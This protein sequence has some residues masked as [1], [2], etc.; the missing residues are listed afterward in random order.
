MYGVYNVIQEIVLQTR[1]VSPLIMGMWRSA[2]EGGLGKRGNERTQQQSNSKFV[3]QYCMTYTR[4]T[5]ILQSFGNYLSLSVNLGW[6]A[7]TWHAQSEYL[8]R[9]VLENLAG[10]EQ[11][12]WLWPHQDWICC[13]YLAFYCLQ[14]WG[15]SSMI[16][17]AMKVLH[18]LTCKSC[19]SDSWSNCNYAG[20][21]H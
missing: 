19:Q 17:Q 3:L 11:L 12:H 14:S 5:R 7:L 13:L 9:H 6:P 15:F 21:Y 8:L 16:K 2:S 18:S 10:T 20:I 4:I 1:T